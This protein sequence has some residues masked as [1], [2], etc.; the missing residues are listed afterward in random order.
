VSPEADSFGV[1]KKLADLLPKL[2]TPVQLAGFVAFLIA[3]VL[4]AKN[5]PLNAVGIVGLGILFVAFVQVFAQ[6]DKIPENSRASFL[7]RSLFLFIIA[8]TLNLA[9]AYF[10]LVLPKST[11]PSRYPPAEQKVIDMTAEMD[12][13]KGDYVSLLDRRDKAPSVNRRARQLAQRLIAVDDGSLSLGIRIY[14]YESVAYL[15]AMVVGSEADAEAKSRAVAEILAAAGKGENLIADAMVFRVP[16][17]KKAQDTRDWIITDNAS[18]RLQRL[19]AIALCARWQLK[20]NPLDRRT[21][22]D[23]IADLPYDYL[24]DEKPQQSSEL[25][26][27]LTDQQ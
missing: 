20:K 12:R 21:V 23:L 2:K 5:S 1:L 3:A 13:I 19:E 15:W 18:P 24:T 27:C 11:P 4:L 16:D 8:F 26:P 25:L 6:L 14:K 7:L 17:S 22:R 9:F 10:V